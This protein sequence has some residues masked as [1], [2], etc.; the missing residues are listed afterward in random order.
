MIP[1]IKKQTAKPISVIRSKSVS[2]KSNP[3][4]NK[5]RPPAPTR[6]Q[7]K[8]SISSKKASDKPSLKLNF[9]RF[10]CRP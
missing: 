7:I 6:K 10:I 5:L 2:D 8:V 1:K 9:L 4:E 3:A